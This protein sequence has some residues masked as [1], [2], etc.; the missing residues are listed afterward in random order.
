MTQP[1]TDL[2]AAV[3]AENTVIDSAVVAFTQLGQMI[4]DSAEDATAVT[5]LGND[6]KGKAAELAAAIPTNTVVTQTQARQKK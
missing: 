5:K 4:I 2:V 1:V 3:A 6:V